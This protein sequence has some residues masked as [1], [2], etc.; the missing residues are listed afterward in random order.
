ME[1]PL[2][3]LVISNLRARTDC[4][5][6]LLVGRVVRIVLVRNN[7]AH[8]TA[9]VTDNGTPSDRSTVLCGIFSFR[10]N[11]ARAEPPTDPRPFIPPSDSTAP[12]ASPTDCGA[13]LTLFDGAPHPSHSVVARLR[14]R[15]RAPDGLVSVSLI[16]TI[17]G[18][19]HPGDRVVRRTRQVGRFTR[20]SE[21]RSSLFH[22]RFCASG[23]S[24]PEARSEPAAE[25]GRLE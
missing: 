22:R 6:E 2:V 11:S 12:H 21:A 20:P 19:E 5:E 13:R 14:S 18:C 4:S 10:S 25:K 24:A 17:F 1:V 15:Q 9:T 7:V 16:L 3:G 8:D 23:S